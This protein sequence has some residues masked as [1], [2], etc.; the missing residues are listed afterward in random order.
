MDTVKVIINGKTVECNK[1]SYVLEAARKAGIEIPTLCEHEMLDPCKGSACRICVVEIEGRK[2]LAPSCST[3]VMDGMVIKTDTERIM[4]TRKIILELLLA[5]HPQDCMTCESAGSCKLQDYAYDYDIKKSRFEPEQDQM[6]EIDDSNEFYIY[7][8]NKCILCR[9]CV[10]VCES[11]QCN[12]SIGF[13]ERGFPTKVSV[14]FNLP[15]SKS[16]CVSCGN[17][18][19]VCPTGALTAKS[20]HKFRAWE[21]KKTKTTCPYCGVG[22]QMN[23]LVKDNKVVGVEP[24]SGLANKGLLCVKGKFGHG[25][26]NHPDRL[27]TPL[28]K[29][30]KGSFEEITW[31]EAY[32]VIVDRIKKTKKDSGSDSLAGLS[33]ARCTN[34]ENY[35]FQKMVRAGFGTNNVDHCARLCHASTV[36]GL[37]TT[38]GSGA[39]TNSNI[40]ALGSD[41]IFISGSNTTETHPVIGAFIKQ[42]K[43]NGTKIIV[44]EPRRIELADKADV[45][46]QI[47]P[48]TNVAIYNGLMHVIIKEGLEDKEYIKERTENYEELKALL[49][50]YTPEKVGKI[51]GV[52]PDD[53]IKA[54]RIYAGGKK[55][56]IYYSMGVTQH[57]TGTQGVM[58]LSNLA[59]LCGNI[60]IE[61]G[62]VNPLRGQNNVQG[63]CDLGCLP[64]DYPG[65]QKVFDKEKNKKF[66]DAW[67]VKLSEKAGLTVT[68][69]MKKGE[70]GEIKFLYIMGENPMISDPDINHVEKALEKI[71]FVVVQDIFMSETAEYADLVLP[72][73]SFAEKDGTFTNT[74]RRVQRIRKAVDL[75]TDAK[76]DW[77]IL[78][79][80]INRLGIESSY[81]SSSDIMDEISTLTPQYGG[82]SYERIEEEGLQWPCPDKNHSGTKYLH[83]GKFARGLGLFKPAPYIESAELPD[84]EYPVILTTGRMLYHFHTRTMTKRVEGIDRLYPKSYIEINPATAHK[85]NIKDNEKIKVISRRGEIE[86]TAAVKDIV[87]EGVVFMPFHFGDGA[88]NYLTNP[89]LDPIAK[90]PEFKVCAVKLEKIV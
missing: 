86:S 8:E 37:A 48:G 32:K 1:D 15:L 60:G 59:L 82:I 88:A 33:S 90:I 10:R 21:V 50:D 72:A 51:C 62:G 78:T 55:S 5:D 54:A 4:E 28:M 39:M 89:V 11:L 66:Q 52:N 81:E 65:Y 9:Q 58:S 69:I 80:I 35:L 74:E 2:N 70:E 36:A 24:L 14:P 53:I 16:T 57:S 3:P 56:A 46:L 42:A 68:E 29:N 22:C 79:E 63:A 85:Y 6:K 49:D 20:R 76:P 31:E 83:K 27:K 23:L 38:L 73:V 87:E 84:D 41:V 71:D 61:S 7:D 25:F 45:F 19:S 44:A 64:G 43:L 34:E 67:G 30:K 40:E 18:V 17:C 12:N 77:E 13:S 75:G 26:V 47:T